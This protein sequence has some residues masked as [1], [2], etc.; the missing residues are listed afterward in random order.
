MALA[1]T[2]C[3]VYK[4]PMA[5]AWSMRTMERSL[6][7]MF[8]SASW[9]CSAAS[10]IAAISST[11]SSGY[12]P[13]AVS[14]LSITASVPSIT[15]LATSLTSARVGTG[16]WIIDSIIWVA[17]MTTLSCLCAKR[18]M[19]FCKA[20]TAALPTSTAKSPRATMMPSLACKMFSSSGMASARSI[21]A[22]NPGR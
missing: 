3:A 9:A 11:V 13:A 2:C 16:F 5:M 20:G 6:P 19:R 15:A 1:P 10:Q 18:I 17:V 8:N 14:A 21:L 7:G 4:A 12:L 22:I